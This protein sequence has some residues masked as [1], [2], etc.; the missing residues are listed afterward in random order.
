RSVLILDEATANIDS[1]TEQ[2][3]QTAIKKAL[4]R[5]TAL[6]IAHRLSTVQHATQ[7]L[8]LDKGTI[9]ERGTHDE[10][11]ARNG[12]YSRLYDMQFRSPQ[13][14]EAAHEVMPVPSFG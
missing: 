7:I 13:H 4:G 11:R 6:V 10:L 14:V 8:V 2:I 5:Q 3:L 12:V 1:I 9:V